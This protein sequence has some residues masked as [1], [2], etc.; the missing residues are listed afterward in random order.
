[1]PWGL[2]LK[3]FAKNT[4]KQAVTGAGK[5]IA[6]KMLGRGKNGQDP[7]QQQS[8][9]DGG[10]GDG[11]GLAQAGSSAIIPTGVKSSA[12]AISQTSAGGGGGQDLE[13]TVLRI[14]TSVIKVEN[15]LAGSAALQ[16]K[17]REDARKATEA[18]EAAAREGELEK[19]KK[20]QKFS[21]PQP[22]IVKSFWEKMK[23]FFLNTLLGFITVRLL[24]FMDKMAPVLKLLVGIGEWALKIAGWA[25]NVLV[26]AIDL[27]Y[28]L[29]DKARGWVGNKFGEDGLKWFDKLSEVAKNLI[30]GFLIWKIIGERIFNAAVGAIKGAW[31]LARNI[32]KGV[33]N[34]GRNIGKGIRRIMHPKKTAE[35]L[36]RV[37]NIKKIKKA[38]ELAKLQKAQK[39]KNIG[40]LRK[41]AKV[42]GVASK[43]VGLAAKGAGKVGGL[44]AKIFGKSAGAISGAFKAAKPFLSKFFG[45][46]PIIGPLVVGIVS[47]LSG[48]PVGQALFKTMGA[49]LGGFLGTFIPIPILGTLIGETLGVFVGD[50]LYTL[51]FGGGMKAVGQKLKDTL[52]GILK[53]G[54]AVKDF[55]VGG[56]GRFWEGIPKFKVPD[57]PDEPPS[58]IPNIWGREALWN[59][60]K[61]GMKVMI[62][63]LSLLMGREIP[64]LLWMYNPL[65]TGPLLAKSFFPPKKEKA[66]DF[67]MGDGGSK[68]AEIEGVSSEASYEEETVVLPPIKIKEG[69]GEKTSAKALFITS[70]VLYGQK[71]GDDPYEKLY[72]GGLG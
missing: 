62:G 69:D 61:L 45:R 72:V 66:P 49:A 33:V 2:A 11:G 29:Y 40:K 48:D 35:A 24:P 60:A 47:I 32:A 51:M 58:W 13:G 46:V 1:M 68:D 22:K 6:G 56:F 37:N 3:A 65:N 59:S 67:K 18:A 38:K 16:E 36:K 54:T 17:Q 10:D 52:T 41:V 57:F 19:P 42:K 53:A 63:P 31:N 44:V 12:L 4:A 9:S 7:Q 5:K 39:I 23:A 64:N 55:V 20:K 15:L 70:G 30:N 25:F 43:G 26:S 34:I 14:K 8:P 21:I 50:L 27:A 28:G 71:Q